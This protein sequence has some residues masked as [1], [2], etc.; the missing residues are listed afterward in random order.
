ML[1]CRNNNLRQDVSMSLQYIEINLADGTHISAP[2]DAYPHL[3]GERIKE[4]G[5]WEAMRWWVWQSIAHARNKKQGTTQKT[6]TLPNK[7][8]L[9]IPHSKSN[10]N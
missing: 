6:K 2:L 10:D 1:V 8:K 5:Q 3:P 9:C 4:R 7:N